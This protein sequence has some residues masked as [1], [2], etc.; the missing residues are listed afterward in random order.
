MSFL[1]RQ[2]KKFYN[3]KDERSELL[4][5]NLFFLKVMQTFLLPMSSQCEKAHTTQTHIQI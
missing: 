5:I 4:D 1:K 2:I 3:L